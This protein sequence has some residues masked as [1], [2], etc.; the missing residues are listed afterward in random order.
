MRVL[1]T[2]SGMENIESINT[3]SYQIAGGNFLY[4]NQESFKYLFD[5]NIYIVRSFYKDSK[6]IFIESKIDKKDDGFYYLCFII[7]GSRFDFKIEK[8]ELGICSHLNI[9]DNLVENITISIK[10]IKT[11]KEE[12]IFSKNLSNRKLKICDAFKNGFNSFSDINNFNIDDYKD[13]R[14]L[15]LEIAGGMGDVLLEQYIISSIIEELNGD[16]TFDVLTVKDHVDFFRLFNKKYIKNIYNM[17]D[18]RDFNDIITDSY[19]TINNSNIL[20]WRCLKGRKEYLPLSDFCL[21]FSKFKNLKCSL[22]NFYNLNNIKFKKIKNRKVGVC[23]VTTSIVKGF[24]RNISKRLI[25][26]LLYNGFQVVN[27]STPL[28]DIDDINFIDNE[29]PIEIY[30][31]IEKMKDL[32][33]VITPDT[34]IMHLSYLLGIPFYSVFS[35]TNPSFILKHIIMDDLFSNKFF[36]EKVDHSGVN[37]IPIEFFNFENIMKFYNNL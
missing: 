26:Y 6:K 19:V 37:E 11:N 8:Q 1:Y 10:D 30:K 25:E 33:F 16:V 14:Y 23:F 15:I 22:N 12:K 9:V 5:N 32:D 35:V 2:I 31:T 4:L 29:Y 36:I 28:E 27:L 20:D 7:D 18:L 17:Y 13:N 3:E 34:G 24:S 21:Y